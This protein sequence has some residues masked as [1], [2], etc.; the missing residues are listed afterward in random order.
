MEVEGLLKDFTVNGSGDRFI[1]AGGCGCRWV[2]L[3]VGGDV[4]RWGCMWMVGGASG[5][6]GCNADISRR[7]GLLQEI[8]GERFPIRRNFET[9]P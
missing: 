3:Q 2:G 4:G 8:S 7:R 5:G 1:T 6:W 9:V